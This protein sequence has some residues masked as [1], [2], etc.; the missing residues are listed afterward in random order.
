MLKKFRNE[1]YKNDLTTHVGDFLESL[2]KD[3]CV[4]EINTIVVPHLNDNGSGLNESI[5]YNTACGQLNV[6]KV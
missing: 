5:D 4:S 6:H 1:K 3:S 2:L